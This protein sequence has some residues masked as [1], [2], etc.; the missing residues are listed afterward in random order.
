MKN[1]IINNNNKKKKKNKI[2]KEKKKNK[3]NNKNI[4]K[5]NY[6]NFEKY[7]PKYIKKKLD[8]Y[9]IGQ[10]NT[11]KKISLAIYN[12]FKIINTKKKNKI[13]NYYKSN[14]IMIGPTG[15]GKTLIIKTISKILN[16]PIVIT[17]AT[18]LTQAGYVGDD[19]ENILLR[20]IQKCKYNIKKA[21]KGIIYID[22]IDKI[23]KKNNNIS[24][25]RDVSGEGVQQSLLKIIEGTIS[26]VPITG[27]RKH[28]LQE[29]ILINTSNI[30]FICGG[31]F[32][33]INKIIKKRINNNKIGFDKKN[34]KIKKNINIKYKD[35]IKFGFIPEFISR[36]SIITKL[37]K[38]NK[39]ELIKI[40]TKTKNSI[41]EYY[42]FLLKLENINLKFT[43]RA[44]NLIAKI[45]IKKKIGAR[46]LKN[47][48]EKILFKIMYDNNKY[49]NKNILINKNFIKKKYKKL[50]I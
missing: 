47:V 48:I 12:H 40:L 3:I 9:I 36:F 35:L 45:S 24:I 29:N 38:L 13:T 5:N 11:K 2:S 30:L 49:I 34:N 31:T 21:E 4:N 18:T 32:N 46:G 25:T 15:C 43:K 23:S 17:D 14:I 6:F 1:K 28:P 27:G 8:K 26:S 44:I 42:K 19:V 22:E 37:N 39:K 50:N 41:I 20:L 10:N 33:N 16:I 7:K